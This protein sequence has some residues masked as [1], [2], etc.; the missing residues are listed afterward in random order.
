MCSTTATSLPTDEA[1]KSTSYKFMMSL[2]S[3][4]YK[5]APCYDIRAF[6]CCSAYEV[7]TAIC[8]GGLLAAGAYGRDTNVMM[9]PPAFAIRCCRRKRRVS[10]AYRSSVTRQSIE[11]RGRA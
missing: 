5:L 4:T 7:I 9:R 8:G 10:R 6:S 3:L 1:R 11:Y 2:S